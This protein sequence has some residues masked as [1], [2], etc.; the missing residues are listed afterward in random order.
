MFNSTAKVI[1][2]D[3]YMDMYSPYYTEAR[4]LPPNANVLIIGAND[5]ISADPTW[6][7]WQDSWFGYFVEPNPYAH[8][9]LKRNRPGICIPYAI[10]SIADVVTLYAMAPEVAK[11]YEHLGM[12]GS[13]LTSYNRK[14][15]E[16]RLLL[17]LKKDIEPKDLDNM[18]QP[19]VVS[20]M[21]IKDL[22][23]E[24]CVPK[25]DLIQ[26]DIEGMEFK[27]VPQCFDINSSIVIWEHKHLSLLR[28][29]QLKW[30]AKAAGYETQE[31]KFDTFAYKP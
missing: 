25:F 18:I 13:H 9:A 24:Y 1:Y 4:K 15:I 20:C 22:L 10:S 16:T 30:L 23:V 17:N 7:V 28:K 11:E 5:G 19:M 29:L 14:H 26:V 6:Q 21:T 31:L 8:E 27:V 3:K 12:N 2:D